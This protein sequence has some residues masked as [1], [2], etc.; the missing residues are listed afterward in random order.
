MGV[1]GVRWVRWRSNFE[2]DLFF[3]SEMGRMVHLGVLWGAL[4]V[5][6]GPCKVSMACWV[7]S[8]V[9]QWHVMRMTVVGCGGLGDGLI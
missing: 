2:L 9:L 1:V 5:V 4:Q 7:V 3:W 8:E 6:N